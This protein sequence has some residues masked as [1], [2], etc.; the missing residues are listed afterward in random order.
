[1]RLAVIN[2]VGL[3]KSLLGPDM[4]GLTKFAEKNG[5]Q[6]Y[7]PAFPAVTCTAQSSIVTGTSPEKHGVVANG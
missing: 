2:L 4:P 7:K 6:T 5:L 3:S 1:M